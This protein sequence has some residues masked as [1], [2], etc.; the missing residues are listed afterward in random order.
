MSGY[1]PSTKKIPPNY[2]EIYL[3]IGV[4]HEIQNSFDNMLQNPE[5]TTKNPL[6]M[7]HRHIKASGKRGVDI[8]N[9]PKMQAL[10][11]SGQKFDLMVYGWFKNDF[12]LGV[13]A[14]FQCPIAVM[15]TVPPLKIVRDMVG[16]PASIASVPF[17]MR[18][19]ADAPRTFT[20]RLMDFIFHTVEFI[21]TNYLR[22]FVI[23]PYY[24]E[25]FPAY[26]N[27]PS[28][29]DVMQ[30][31]SLLMVNSHFS[32]GKPRPYLP[33]VIEISGIQVK[34]KPDPL[35]QVR[36]IQIFLQSFGTFSFNQNRF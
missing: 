33:N 12:L 16:N 11:N 35:P 24:N 7:L 32:M 29:G 8:L 27:Y 9:H 17:V 15:V 25:H 3:D 22:Y 4:L 1:P 6:T 20:I 23:E 13:G 36:F 30:N 21:I 34:D 2:H 26:K 10:M 18:S 28:Y 19:Q 5:E 14:H 31:I